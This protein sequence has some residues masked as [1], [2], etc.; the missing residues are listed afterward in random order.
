MVASVLREAGYKTLAKTTGSKPML[1][2]PDGTEKDIRR[3]GR[4]SILEQKKILKLAARLGVEAIVCEMMSIKPECLRAES[5]QFLR[6]HVLLIT[7][8]RLDHVEDMGVTKPEIAKSMAEAVSGGST[9]LVPGEECYPAFL[10]AAERVGASVERVPRPPSQTNSTGGGAGSRLEF[11][12]N[13]NLALAVADFLKVDRETARRGIKKAI[14]DFGSLKVWQLRMDDP[15][16]TWHAASLF[17]ANDP[18]SSGRALAHL[19]SWNIVFPNRMIGLL[20]L[21]QDR[22]DRTLQWLH[23]LEKGF[24]S[25]F[26]RLVFIGDHAHALGRGHKRPG[27]LS[28]QISALPGKDPLTIMNH[29][30]AG[31]LGEVL[32]VGLGNMG[33]VG[34]KLVNYWAMAGE[35]VS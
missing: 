1:I 14:P 10:E 25:D 12:E 32:L 34:E 3:T 2:L 20:N 31:E 6:P 9:V 16:R 30:A 24:F 8:V 21:R 19:K 18:E 22:G 23:V 15:D 26:Q 27:Q 29:L 13:Q 11:E 17:A 28:L 4:P 5:R 35:R 7:N 33:G